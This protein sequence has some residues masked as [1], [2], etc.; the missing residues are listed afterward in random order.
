M[1]GDPGPPGPFGPPGQG[2]FN[3]IPYSKMITIFHFQKLKW[4]FG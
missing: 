2:E 3:E 1:K 4:N